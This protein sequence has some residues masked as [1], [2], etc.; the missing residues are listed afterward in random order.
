VLAQ[1]SL[2]IEEQMPWERS[3]YENGACLNACK[4]VLL[5]EKFSI[6]GVLLILRS[7]CTVFMELANSLHFTCLHSNQVLECR[8]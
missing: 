3:T 7:L 1:P 2:V 4:C 8:E 6:K 5:G